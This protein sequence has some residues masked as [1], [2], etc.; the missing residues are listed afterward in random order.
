MKPKLSP[1]SLLSYVVSP[2]GLALFSTTL[3]LFAW[4]FP[5]QAYSDIIGEP[6]YMHLDALTLLFFLLCLIGFFTGN[7]LSD[8]LFQPASSVGEDFTPKVEGIYLALPLL[9]TTLLT[10]CEAYK[11]L[12]LSPNFVALLLLQQGGAIKQNPQVREIGAIGLANYFHMGVLWWTYWRIR[13]S[14]EKK[15]WQMYRRILFTIGLFSVFVVSF[16]TLSRGGLMSVFAGLA[17]LYLMSMIRSGELS[18]RKLLHFGLTALA[19]FAILN[20]IFVISRGRTDLNQTGAGIVGYSL[21]SYNRLAA[22][23]HG[24]L[25][26]PYGGHGVYLSPFA[27]YSNLFNEI[28]PLQK[29]MHWPDF[30]EVWGSEFLAVQVAGLNPLLIWSGTFGYL[31]ADLGWGT[32]L[33]MVIYGILYGFFW[34]QAKRGTTT[35][36]IVYPYFAFCV[37]MWF[38]T[39]SL[40]DTTLPPLLITAFLLVLYEKRFNVASLL[41]AH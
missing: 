10:L 7:A 4:F 13:T 3:F 39:N 12:A 1:P 28:L 34:N 11:L 32:P 25:R 6:D 29:I 26:Y 30:Y 20:M 40:F 41:P 27:A 15:P 17:V 16:L 33:A 18:Y 31:F 8:L 36:V 35:G 38:S 21:A 23:L 24:K 14:S 5:S 19:G 22:M 2:Y 37:L 9:I